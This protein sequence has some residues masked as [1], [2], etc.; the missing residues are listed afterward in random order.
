MGFIYILLK[1]VVFIVQQIHEMMRE[2]FKQLKSF[3]CHLQFALAVMMVMVM[4]M[5]M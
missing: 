4:R 1:A 5:M 2:I 3:E